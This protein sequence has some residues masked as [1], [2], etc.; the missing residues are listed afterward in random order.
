MNPIVPMNGPS[1][2]STA[3]VTANQK[4]ITRQRVAAMQSS[5]IPIHISPCESPR[6]KVAGSGLWSESADQQGEIH[7][8]VKAGDELEPPEGDDARERCWLALT[9]RVHRFRRR[10]KSGAGEQRAHRAQR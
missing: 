4:G 7:A 10:A 3:T 5:D 1:P 6:M 8:R 2:P 9:H